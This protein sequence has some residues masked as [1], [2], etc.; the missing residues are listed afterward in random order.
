ME[1]I[2]EASVTLGGPVG[3]AA[4]E[5]AFLRREAPLTALLAD[6]TRLAEAC[7]DM[8]ERFRRGG[9]LLVFG[10]G[11]GAT[12]AQHI[13]VEFVHPVIVGKAALPAL[14]LVSDAATVM[15]VAARSGLE[16]VYAHQIEVLGRPEDIALG[17]SG[18]G[19]CANVRAGLRAARRAGLLTV[20]LVGGDGGAICASGTAEHALVLRSEDPLVVKEAAVTAYHLL[21]E[22]VHVFLESPG[23][24][25]GTAPT[26]GG[27]EGLYP[28]LYGGGTD[29]APVL[30]AAAASAREKVHE[31]LQLRRE[32]GTAQAPALAACARDLAA[33]FEAGAT[34]L[35]FGN[36]GS[37]T[38]AQD[39]AHTFLDPPGAGRAL[40]ALCLTSD[41]AVLTALSNDVSFEVVFARQVRAFGRA[42]DIA[43]ALST[44]GGSANVLAA[45]EE[46]R[47]VG[48]TTVG[49]AGYGGGPMASLSCLDHLFAVPSSSVHRVQEVQTTVYHVLWEATRDALVR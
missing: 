6:A 21:W 39:V 10:N 40:P 29:A 8:A 5:E 19:S 26:A 31:I 38:D 32:V 33:A 37:S 13:A 2:E 30:E 7:R 34:L 25:E 22:L 28:F 12:D 45:L 15:G 27:V 43:L 35:S 11:A 49:L 17:L 16:G 47:A 42:G 9:R 46:A 44:S 20:A 36:G 4:V 3:T 48:M 18:D 14:S 41:V 24:A 23:A 1:Q